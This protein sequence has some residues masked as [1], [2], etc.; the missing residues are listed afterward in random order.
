VSFFHGGLENEIYGA[1][2]DLQIL[3]GNLK[4]KFFFCSDEAEGAKIL[5]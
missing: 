2:R 3:F 5:L 1:F 4:F